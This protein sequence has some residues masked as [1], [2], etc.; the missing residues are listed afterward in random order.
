MRILDR[1]E[2]HLAHGPLLLAGALGTELLR[3]GHPTPLP[4]WS[5]AALGAAP[6]A[7][8]ALH[9]DHVR[10]GACVVTANTFRT[11][12]ATV[13]PHG[14]DPRALTRRAVSLAREGVA[15]AGTARDILVAGSVGPV[16]D[17]YRP[18][19]V[20]DEPTLRAEHG[21]HVG[22]LV[23]ARADLAL[24]ETMGTIREAVAALGATRAG[25]LP[26]MVSF[27]VDDRARLLSGESLTDA[28]RAVE[29]LEPLAIL[30]NC[31]DP[32]AAT[33]AVQGLAAAT[34]RPVGAYANGEGR[35]DDRDGWSFDG[36]TPDD[37]YVEHA[38]DWLDAGARILGG[39]CGTTPET[40]A[41]LA[42][43]AAPAE[44]DRPA[45]QDP[46]RP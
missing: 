35:P 36:G 33:R 45:T 13:A 20:P 38:R 30:V 41:R 4:L 17:C 2:M 15:A 18:D 40:I 6:E 22:A 5:T 10:A 8:A 7:V 27:A 44:D 9:A 12:R 31:C 43:L 16:A 25:L 34:T 24:V 3:R 29:P 42:A 32:A 28:V 46:R 11:G 14:L 37:A 39:C 26:A 19:L 23:A 1:L 21:L